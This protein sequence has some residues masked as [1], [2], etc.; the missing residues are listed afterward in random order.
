[1]DEAVREL[2]EHFGGLPNPAE[3]EDIWTE[4][5]QEE[6][7]NSTALEGNTLVKREV[8]KL[9]ADGKAVG[10]KSLKDYMEVRG[11]ADAA[12]WVYGQALEPGD[13]ND[14]SLVTLQEVR[15]VHYILMALVWS[16]EPHPDATD[17]EG[18]GNFRRHEIAAFSAGMRPPPWVEVDARMHAWIAAANAVQ[19]S[20]GDR[21]LPEELARLHADFESIHP[22]LDGNGRA[23]RLALNLLLG[24][25]GY[26]PA[27]IHKR[28]RDRYL[29]ALQRA[30]RGECGPL[31]EMIA[32]SVTTNL[33]RF[34]V[35]AV[36]GPARLVP[37][38]A[39]ASEQITEAAL[40]SAAGRN[41]LRATQ[42]EDGQWRS[43]RNWVDEYLKNRWRRGK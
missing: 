39:L 42:G 31:A 34:V 8:A 30:D 37:L 23:G 13:W 33:H 18:P 35:P 24:R 16:V 7:H 2:R 22:F 32:R 9:L 17:H 25:L 12:R 10:S 40:R 4:L 27:I 43:S 19:T 6:A 14:G 29:S 41:K 1:M 38:A 26:P 21:C 15:H 5:W 3:A 20:A 11:Y 36:A 28:D